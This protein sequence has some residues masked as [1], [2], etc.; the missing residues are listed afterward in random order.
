MQRSLLSRRPLPGISA[1]QAIDEVLRHVAF[2]RP[3]WCVGI[4]QPTPFDGFEYF[5]IG[6]S[7]ERRVA[8]QHNV[9]DDADGPY[10]AG[11]VVLAL[12]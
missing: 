2:A 10:I 11:L 8:A 1:Q 7:I 6:I 4:L 5:A 12:E 3:S 9:C